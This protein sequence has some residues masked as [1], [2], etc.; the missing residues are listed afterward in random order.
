V[1]DIID[2]HQHYW[3]YDARD[4]GWIGEDMAAI[5]RDF[6]PED[7]KR[8]MDAAGVAA[9]VAVQVRQT[10]EETRWFLELARQ[11][12]FIA[13]VVGWVDLQSPAVGDDLDAL[14]GERAL[15]GIRH[16]VQAEP[17]D[18]MARPA[19]RRG[20][21]ELQARGLPYDILVYARQ[22]GAAADLVD[23]LPDQRFLLDHLGKPDIRA[24]GYDAW[25]R[26]FDRLGE[27]ANVWCKLSGLVTEADWRRWTPAMLAPY[28]DHALEVFGPRRLMVGSDWPVCTVAAT[29]AEAMSLVV[30]A[31]AEYSADERA[32]VLSGTARQFWN[33]VEGPV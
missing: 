26:D 29:Y 22:L 6:M 11:H 31:L 24:G 10:T 19:F 32:A 18:F 4:Y 23:A 25:R 7:A 8:E 2:T 28:L 17:D 5:R 21:R 20:L 30:D 9:S 27:R 15:V 33:L 1:A 16:I 13:G 14:A 3:R 12:P